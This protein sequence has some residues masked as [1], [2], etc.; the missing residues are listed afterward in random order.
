MMTAEQKLEALKLLFD[1]QKAYYKE[2]AGGPSHVLANS[3][4]EA[5]KILFPN[6]ID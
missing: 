3:A 1:L 4:L 6:G 5:L 2:V